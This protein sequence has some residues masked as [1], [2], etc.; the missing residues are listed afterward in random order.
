MGF[1]LSHVVA[2]LLLALLFH[3][4]GWL[5]ERVAFR[6]QAA[7]W[8]TLVTRQALGMGVWIAVA[9]ALAASGFAT[10]WMV[11]GLAGL[12]ALAFTAALVSGAVAPRMDGWRNRGFL[13][14][15]VAIS[16]TALG[17][18]L[19]ALLLQTLWPAV[20]WDSN[21]YHLTVPRLWAEHGG[22]RPVAFN[23]YSNWPLNT[24]LLFLV[25]ILLR[26]YVLAK[27]VHYWLGALT[28]VAV[29]WVVRRSVGPLYGL[30]AAALVLC[31]QVVLA[32]FRV[33]YVDLA[34]AFFFFVAFLLLDAALRQDRLMPRDLA[35]VGLLAGLVTGIKL[36]GIVGVLCLAI[37]LSLEWH[38]RRPATGSLLKALAVLVLPSVVVLLA[39]F[40]KSW[41]FTGNPVYPFLYAVFGGPSWSL[42]LGE[43]LR[44][45]Q[46][47]IGMGRG[48]VDYLLLPIRVILMGG[49]GYDR[50]DGQINAL[51]LAW[52]PL[53]LWM[54]RKSDLVR[55][56]LWVAGLYFV[57][58]S[59]TSQQ[60]RFLIPVLPF[61][62][63]AAA[64]SMAEL[65]SRVRHGKGRR[66]G[67]FLVPFTVVLVVVLTGGRYMVGGWRLA[68]VFL[69]EG[70]SVQQSVVH[71]VYRFINESLP[72]EARLLMLNTNHGFFCHREYLAD[73]FFEASQTRDL[74]KDCE[75]KLEVAELLRSTGLTHVL[76]E[77]HDL[78]IGYP[79]AFLDFLTRPGRLA[80]E[81]YRSED[82]RFVLLELR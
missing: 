62:A 40:A 80:E 11:Y 73:S 22:F 48:A 21:V 39:W 56:C 25:A 28:L 52:I 77:T 47:S 78:G 54:A 76:I 4:S 3:I 60:M 50:F 55:R 27:L 33:A 31:N 37:L 43:M 69:T 66:L 23:V 67:E 53:S 24:E 65:L 82:D 10:S 46:R 9:F 36:T 13:G 61:L 51:W 32:E 35:V 63:T 14:L 17:L 29:F 2:L 44:D 70:G 15:G 74:V 42:E 38:R 41:L 1:I 7:L 18:L 71:P 20:G 79:R 30:L 26:D 57:A 6:H 45:W 68:G 58:W 72:E 81:I 49:R 12:F 64:C 34:F 8:P 75:T 59:L 19:G 5:V 16:A